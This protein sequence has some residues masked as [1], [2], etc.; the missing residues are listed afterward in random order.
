MAL[1]RKMSISGINLDE[2]TLTLLLNRSRLDGLH[3]SAPAIDSL[4]Q[5]AT[6]RTHAV[7]QRSTY[8]AIIFAY[9]HANRDP[10][11]QQWMHLMSKANIPV[12][13]DTYI[14]LLE[15]AA[16]LTQS[17]ERVGTLLLFAAVFLYPFL[18][19]GLYSYGGTRV[20]ASPNRNVLIRPNSSPSSLPVSPVTA[21]RDR[22]D[23][24]VDMVDT[25]DV[26][27]NREYYW[28]SNYLIKNSSR[29]R[30]IFKCVSFI[31][32]SLLVF[33]DVFQKHF[34]AQIVGQCRT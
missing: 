11:V 9:A 32:F 21:S 2:A 3:Q 15:A 33:I 30:F 5:L 24:G 16:A 17:Y 1:V 14:L 29:V 12:T 7:F 22:L 19:R 18:P 23:A 27:V 13:V 10:K 6:S 8:H 34:V 25:Y 4:V 20:G 28:N 26:C 31:I